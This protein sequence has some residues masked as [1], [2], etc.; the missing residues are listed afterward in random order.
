MKWHFGYMDYH[1]L[2]QK[3]ITEIKKKEIFSVNGYDMPY[4]R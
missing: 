3:S 2:D 1:G 4:K